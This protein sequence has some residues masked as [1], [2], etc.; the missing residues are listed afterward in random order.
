MGAARFNYHKPREDGYNPY[1][2]NFSSRQKEIIWGFPVDRLKMQEI[3]V[4]L[5]KAERL[6]LN[7]VYEMVYDRYEEMITGRS[8][9]KYTLEEAKEI[10]RKLTPWDS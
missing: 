8:P 9:P 10:L 3:S 7:S 5:R 1:G 6:G 2:A 4:I